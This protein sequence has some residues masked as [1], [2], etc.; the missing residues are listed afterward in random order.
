MICKKCSTENAP[1]KKT[2]SNCHSILVGN[3]INN[4]TGE[5][6]FRNKKGLFIPKN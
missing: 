1:I 4:V 6:G 2:C 3:T 5:I